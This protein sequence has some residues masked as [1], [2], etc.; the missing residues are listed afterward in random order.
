MRVI[1][2]EAVFNT[3]KTSIWGN[4]LVVQWL[5]FQA[6]NAGGLGSIP[7]QETR[8]HISQRRS[9]ILHAATKTQLCCCCS[10][11]QLCPTLY[12]PMD[13]SLPGSSVHGISLARSRLPFPSPGNLPDPGIEPMSPALAGGFFTT[14]TPGKPS[15][16]S[17]H[18][19]LV[20]MATVFWV[21]TVLRN[22]WWT[23]AHWFVHYNC[24]WETQSQMPWALASPP[25]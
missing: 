15:Q 23:Q 3:I 21:C 6:P 4:S 18:Q 24:E 5:I 13:C 20:T 9:K 8:F 1:I 7:S 14:E 22:R 2:K 11:A 12:D 19:V 17:K 25:P 10:A 16:H